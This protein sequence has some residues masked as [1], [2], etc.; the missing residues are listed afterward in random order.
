[1]MQ[2]SRNLD[3]CLTSKVAAMSNPSAPSKEDKIN[4]PKKASEATQNN[5]VRIALWAAA[6]ESNA[7]RAERVRA[8][9]GK[10]DVRL[11]NTKAKDYEMK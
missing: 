10:R 2:R 11:E 4:A 1:M 9:I 6:G 3:V 5:K 7:A 8:S